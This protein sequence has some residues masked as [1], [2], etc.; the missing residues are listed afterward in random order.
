MELADEM[1]DLRE[2]FFKS[3]GIADQISEA[4]H[5]IGCKHQIQYGNGWK[6]I[7]VEIDAP[8]I[9]RMLI[10][11]ANSILF[12][13][14][15]LDGTEQSWL[16]HLTDHNTIISRIW[17]CLYLISQRNKVWIPFTAYESLVLA[18]WLQSETGSD[19]YVLLTV[20]ND[21]SESEVTGIK[22]TDPDLIAAA[23][24]VLLDQCPGEVF[25][26]LLCEKYEV[27]NKLRYKESESHGGKQ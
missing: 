14:I 1:R 17:S 26:D 10:Q 12:S 25:L 4:L 21:D 3:G 19:H 16:V 18:L 13:Y 11:D 6:D 9:V 5:L 15:I 2:L 24:S 7:R 27:F 23:R 20:C 8:G 22:T